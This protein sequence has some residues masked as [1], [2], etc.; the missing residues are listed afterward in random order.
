MEN[1]AR[2]SGARISEHVICP[3]DT[4]YAGTAA[5]RYNTFESRPT[6]FARTIA[7]R[8]A[9]FYEE[10]SIVDINP[11]VLDIGCGTGQ[12]AS[13]L[14][15]VGIPVTGIDPSKAMIDHA[16]RNNA[17]HVSAGLA[18]FHVMDGAELDLPDTYGLAVAT[19]NTLNHFP[20]HQRLNSCLKRI[21]EA[22]DPGGCFL[23]DID[24]L[25]GLERLAEVAELSNTPDETTFRIRRWDGNRL[26]LY[27]TGWFL[28][29][30]YRWRYCETIRKIVIDTDELRRM[31]TAIGLTD[32]RYTTEDYT[33]TV[34]NPE[35]STRAY[36]VA[37]KR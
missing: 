5:L 35:G 18:R 9:A 19:F 34:E 27:A 33:T 21:F 16:Y 31:L 14:L 37:W 24:T 32:L 7:P 8:L 25:H 29:S 20:S 23:F 12:L 30:E 4:A 36:G 10:R 13:Y 17:G 28:S 15:D 26:E 3:D 22:L 2:R 1:V 11:A 6:G